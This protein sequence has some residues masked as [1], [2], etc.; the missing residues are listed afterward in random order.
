MQAQQKMFS[1]T[2]TV[3]SIRLLWQEQS[4]QIIQA[5][6]KKQVK[7]QLKAMMLK[8]KILRMEQVN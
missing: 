3:K 5:Q 4:L 8:C 7:M 6:D 2:Q 1:K